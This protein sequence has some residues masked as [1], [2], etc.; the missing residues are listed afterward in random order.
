MMVFNCPHCGKKLTVGEQYAGQASQ[1]P[2]CGTALTVP[3]FVRPSDPGM[4]AEY[5]ILVMM[6]TCI[7]LSTVIGGLAN[8]V[9]VKVSPMFFRAFM[10]LIIDIQR[11]A[12]AQGILLGLGYG[13]LFAV[14]LAGVVSF[15][16]RGDF[17]LATTL[18]MIL[19][20]SLLG[21][22]GYVCGALAGMGFAALS[23]DFY[24]QTFMNGMT[25][26]H[27]EI[28]RFAWAG[29]AFFGIV[30]GG[31]LAIFLVSGVF[32]GQWRKRR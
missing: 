32:V 3:P 25:G 6:L 14:L 7:A 18:R 4:K 20:Y 28:I 12:I 15:T 19:A 31:F 11:A 1:C 21:P 9:S 17:N 24:Q 5:R 26:E 30:G 8:T 27:S 16:T 13:V 22:A 29:G 10:P 2:D 23:P